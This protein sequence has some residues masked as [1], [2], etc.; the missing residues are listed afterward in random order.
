MCPED[1]FRD[2]KQRMGFGRFQQGSARK[3]TEKDTVGNSFHSMS[4]EE[5][6]KRV[7]EYKKFSGVLEDKRIREKIKTT[8]SSIGCSCRSRFSHPTQPPTLDL[9]PRSSIE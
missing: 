6:S 3:K 2:R 7:D 8:I 5:F 4:A 9:P 1:V